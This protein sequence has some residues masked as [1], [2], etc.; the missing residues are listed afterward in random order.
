[1]EDTRVVPID[2]DPVH[3]GLDG[4]VRVW[5]GSSPGQST[6]APKSPTDQRQGYELFR[7]KRLGLPQA[8]RTRAVLSAEPR[9]A[10]GSHRVDVAP[11]RAVTPQCGLRRVA[12]S[13]PEVRGP[14]PEAREG[15]R[16]RHQGE[17]VAPPISERRRAVRR[18]PRSRSSGRCPGE[19]PGQAA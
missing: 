1:M 19:W 5:V 17:S 9:R 14:P 8:T 3:V 10:H 4:H 7:R 6:L 2:E 18:A 12:S 11:L 13:H 15:T 16:L